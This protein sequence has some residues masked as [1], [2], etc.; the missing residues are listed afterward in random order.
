MTSIV[1]VGQS[2]FV[3]VPIDEDSS[4]RIINC[5]QSLSELEESPTMQQIFLHD[6]RAT[7]SK[8]LGAQEVHLFYVDVS[9]Q[10]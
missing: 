1:R 9:Q 8:M 5:I 7:F 6:T 4:E 3:T 10:G 2:K